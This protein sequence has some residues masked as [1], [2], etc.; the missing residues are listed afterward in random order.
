M[1]F[2]QFSWKNQLIFAAMVIAAGN[3]G[4]FIGSLLH[5]VVR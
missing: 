2:P 5:A 3:G 1:S 4:Y